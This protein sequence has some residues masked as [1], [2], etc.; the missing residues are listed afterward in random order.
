[1][2]DAGEQNPYYA[3]RSEAREQADRLSAEGPLDYGVRR[4]FKGWQVYCSSIENTW[5][6]NLATWTLAVPSALGLGFVL[7]PSCDL[8]H[9]RE[10]RRAPRWLRPTQPLRS[11]WRLVSLSLVDLRFAFVTVRTGRGGRSPLHVLRVT[12]QPQPRRR[13]PVQAAAI[14]AAANGSEPPARAL[15]GLERGPKRPGPSR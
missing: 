5:Y 13:V 4:S 15:A 8:G 7:V 14:T 11:S 9:E 6:E 10:D 2:D 12:G 3:T 1:M